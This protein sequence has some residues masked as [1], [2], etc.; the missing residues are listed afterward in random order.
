MDEVAPKRAI[1]ADVARRAGVSIATVSRVVNG[2][3]RVTET[4]A[5]RYGLPSPNS[6]MSP[7]PLP[8]VW[9]AG[10]PVLSD[11]SF[12]KSAANSSRPSCA[13]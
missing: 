9:P 2:T 12:R 6:N 4:T 10:A 13:A 8:A 5:Q 1:I 11:C 7:A 3:S